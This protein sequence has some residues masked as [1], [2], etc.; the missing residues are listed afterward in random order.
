MSNGIVCR[1]NIQATSINVHFGLAFE[2]V[3]Q[4]IIILMEIVSYMCVLYSP[5]HIMMIIIISMC[6]YLM[7]VYVY[8][9]CWARHLWIVF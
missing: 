7:F 4:S 5:N 8:F 2:F 6:V 9:N 3:L 1:M